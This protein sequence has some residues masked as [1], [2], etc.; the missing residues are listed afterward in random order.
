[1]RQVVDREVVFGLLARVRLQHD[2]EQRLTE[3]LSDYEMSNISEKNVA[4]ALRQDYSGVSN[5]FLADVYE[6]I[7]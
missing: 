2:N 7:C 5:G 6:A 3:L 4:A 1:M